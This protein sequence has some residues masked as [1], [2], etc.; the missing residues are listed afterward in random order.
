MAKDLL[1][2]ESPTK[3]K[4]ISRLLK[5]KFL[6]F[7]TKGH[8]KD[9]PKSK[10]GVDIKH[11]F[12][13]YYIKIK[14]KAKIINT[15][16]EMAKKAKN[17]YIGTDPDREGEAIA[18]HIAQE[19]GR[20]EIK[21]VLLYE[22]TKDG[23]D[24]AFNNLTTI[25]YNRVDAHKA[26]RVL[27]R[28]VGYLVS[29]LLWKTIRRG[30]SAGRVQSV[31]LRL[32]SERERE[33]KEFKP[34][35]YWIVKGIFRVPKTRNRFQAELYKI[36]NRRPLI[37]S[38]EDVLKIEGE[39]PRET[40]FLVSKITESEKHYSPLPPFIT[41]TLQ[42]EASIR[43]HF[44]AKKTMNIAQ[45]LFEGVELKSETTGLITYPR[46]DS[47]RIADRFIKTTRDFI[48]ENF[49]D[50]FLPPVKR[51]YKDKRETQGAHEGIR[52]TSIERRPERI[53]EFL[54]PDQ[55][56]L[57]KL[58]YDRF[59]ASQMSDSVYKRVEV[60]LNYKGYTFK[61]DSLRMD[62]AG[63][64][65]VYPVD[66]KK[67]SDIPHLNEGQIVILE[68]LKPEQKFTQPPPRYTEATLIKTL[69]KNGIGR[70]S[71]YASIISTLFQRGYVKREKR[72][73][74]PT[75]LGLLVNDIL[76]PRFKRIFEI[77]FTREMEEE[78]DKIEAGKEEWQKVVRGFYNPFIKE[79]K[80][81]E[82]EIGE[83]REKIIEETDRVCPKCGKRLVI[84]WGRYGK[85]YACSGFPE[86]DYR[87]SIEETI[88]VK[89]KCPQCG[90]PLVLRD[91]RYGKFYACSGFPECKYTRPMEDKID[92][93]CPKCGRPLR[94]KISK[95]GKFLA[96]SG[97]PECKYTERLK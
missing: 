56:K 58:I 46:T 71:T 77:G 48:K 40:E 31:A 44:P 51:V 19:L 10:L 85:F 22:I 14:G 5:N 27:D 17:V 12:K 67:G 23:I 50:R 84:R 81:V 70:P 52:P 16:K 42:Q 82:E 37:K 43:L 13:P 72:N 8:I 39:L 69:E 34:E 11:N 74:Y 33:I 60:E 47:H 35:E 9:L 75:E 66:R 18:Y 57:Y 4:T 20:D 95:Y 89:E 25:D 24:E 94:V 79:V 41:S 64:E 36:E 80:G 1:I 54:S 45:T 3:A 97:Y 92:K 61:A 83:I 59:L 6:V 88:Q 63:F 78:L 29:P 7:S 65:K 38:K 96:C 90:K 68:E 2:V 73:L 86:C 21:R 76:I 30:L 26:R 32:I 91:G 49:G 15:L 93:V 28:L 62:F 53:K 87:E 55:F